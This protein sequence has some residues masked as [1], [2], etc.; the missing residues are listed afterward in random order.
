MSDSIHAHFDS[1]LL[2]AAKECYRL[3]YKPTEFMRMV[4]P[5]SNGWGL[6]NRAG[7]QGLLNRERHADQGKD[8]VPGAGAMGHVHP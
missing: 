6:G 7:V 8:R 1:S 3:G 2:A 4:S 5:V